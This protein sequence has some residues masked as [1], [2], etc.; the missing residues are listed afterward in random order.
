MSR[1]TDQALVLSLVPY[2]DLDLMVNLLCEGRGL[3]SCKAPSA[4]NSQKRFQGGLDR[5]CLFE[6]ELEEKPGRSSATGRMSLGGARLLRGFQGLRRTLGGL[7]AADALL[8]FVVA[9]ARQSAHGLEG[10]S[11]EVNPFFTEVLH[12]LSFLD[13]APEAQTT[14]ALLA[15]VLRLAAQEGFCQGEARCAVCGAE[16]AGLCF[17]RRDLSLHCPQHAPRDATY[18]LGPAACQFFAAAPNCQNIPPVALSPLATKELTV[19]VEHL[20]A[21]LSPTRQEAF[22]FWRGLQ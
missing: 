2:R 14:P 9:L 16:G 18:R 1:F 5:H 13:Q 17:S 10:T 15:S 3:V 21:E 22:K 4:R 7:A 11:G 12:F 20:Y 6:V 8:E 19:F